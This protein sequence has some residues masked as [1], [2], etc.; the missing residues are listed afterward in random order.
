[1]TVVAAPVL[2]LA[3]VLLGLAYWGLV[4]LHAMDFLGLVKR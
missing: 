3:G 1:L 4:E 2:A